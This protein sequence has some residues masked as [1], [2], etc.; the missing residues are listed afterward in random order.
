M[1]TFYHRIRFVVP[2]E[3]VAVLVADC[4]DHSHRLLEV[5]EEHPPVAPSLSDTPS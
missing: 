5:V 3:V 1:Q 2:E 4:N